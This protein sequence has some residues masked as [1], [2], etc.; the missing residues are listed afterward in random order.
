MVGFYENKTYDR[1]DLFFTKYKYL[2]KGTK[3]EIKKD[4]TFHIQTCG[5]I[6]DGTWSVK[7]DSLIL[8]IIKGYDGRDSTPITRFRKVY[9]IDGSELNNEFLIDGKKTLDCL[10]KTK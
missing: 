3:M 4:S 9:I 7:S 5:S 1:F 2:T 10:I 8:E 6:M